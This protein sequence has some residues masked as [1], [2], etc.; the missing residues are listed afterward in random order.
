MASYM[1]VEPLS[2]K[3]FSGGL[4]DNFLQG[5]ARRYAKAD[6]F[7]ITV[8]HKLE[9]RYG[10]VV[11]D[12]V[13]YQLPAPG[14]VTS[15]FTFINESILLAQNN[16]DFFYLPSASSTW[17]AIKGPTGNEALGGGTNYNQVTTAEFQHQ[18]YF[19][20]DAGIQPGKL[21][22]DQNGN[23][24]TLTAGIPRM[25]WVPNYPTDASLLQACITLANALRA[26]FVQHFQDAANLSS[27]NDPRFQHKLV[28]KWSLSYFQSQTW[29]LFDTEYPGP[30]PTPTPAPSATDQT[31]LFNLCLA[32]ALSFEHHR[33]DL[34]GATPSATVPSSGN[35]TY[36][37]DIYY[38]TNQRPS[39]LGINARMLTSGAV[40][41]LTKAAAFLDELAQKWYWH[42][43]SP[44]SHSSTNDYTVMSRYLITASKV[45]TIYQSALTMQVT[46]NYTDYAAFAAWIKKTWN[47]HV[48]NSG[49][50]SSSPHVQVDALNSCTLPDPF[51]YDSASLVLFWTRWAYGNNHLID[52]N[53]GTHTGVTFDTTAAS[54][55]LANV[56]TT[57]TGVALTLP[58]GTNVVTSTA[59]FGDTTVL[60]RRIA[61]VISS[62][63]GTAVLSKPA[64]NT[65]TGTLGQYSS[66]NLHV[67]YLNGSQFKDTTTTTEN[68]ANEALA[69]SIG[70]IGTDLIS[71]IQLAT[72]FLSCYAAHLSNGASHFVGYFMGNDLQGASAING[73]PFYVP[74]AA[75]YTWAAYYN[76]Q[77]T[78]EPNGIIYLTRGNPVISNSVQVLQTYPV[79]TIITSLNSNYY[80]SSTIIQENA[81]ASIVGIPPLVNTSLTNYDTVTSVAPIPSTGNSPDLTIEL[82]RTTNGGTTFFS[83][84]SL[85]NSTASYADVT[86]ELFPRPGDTALN[87]KSVIYTSGGV[88]GNDQPPVCQFIHALNGYVYYGAITDTGQFFPQRIR[89]SN[90][91][92][93]DSAPATNFDDLE[94]ALVG[95]SSNRSNLIALCKNSVYRVSGVFTSTGQGSMAHE[96]I[97]DAIGALNAKS[98]VKTEIGVFFAGTDG[99]YYTDGYQLIKISIEL[100]K[101][102]RSFTTSDTQKARI[103]GCYDKLTRRIWWAMQSSQTGTDNDTFFVFYLNYGVKPDGVFTQAMTKSSWQPSSAIFYKGQL[104]IGDSRGYLLKTDQWT[105]TDPLI[106]TTTTPANWQT[107]YLPYDFRTCALDMG[108]I[109]NRK[110]ITKL[111]AIGENVG[112]AAI[113]V[114]SINDNNA[115]PNGIRGLPPIQY[116]GNPMWGDPSVVWGTASYQWKYDGKMDVWRRFPAGSMRSNFKQVQYS[117]GNFVVYRSADWPLGSTANVSKSGLSAAIATPT[118]YTSIVWPND[119][120]NYVV[121]FDTDGY[122]TTYSITAL[123][124]DK[125]TLTLSDPNGTLANNAAANWQISGIK[126]EQRIKITAF[127]VHFAMLAQGEDSASPAPS[128]AGSVEINP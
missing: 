115:G 109:S 87:L 78:V 19:T 39:G 51:D 12:S 122:V 26:S 105:K 47:I 75:A 61:T 53:F 67:S 32:L 118:G 74:T 124:V 62:G 23:W 52:S 101:T 33:N 30:T 104:V 99:F 58:V 89:Q 20:S 96:R 9:M 121:S 113:Q 102:Y 126:K 91:L 112:N 103:Y 54:T 116:L 82:Y 85:T 70:S 14:R 60:N 5:D 17:N 98:I 81:C 80:N 4:T 31:S 117:P 128:G 45:G 57:A 66:S 22:L 40:T 107:T 16:R 68:Q 21:F 24:K 36:H 71:W 88:L 93:P 42:Q 125:K 110:W 18:L 92:A 49:G 90:Q 11:Y 127:D 94:D 114:N 63:S 37:A 43:L 29:S 7:L 44:L 28:D 83:L 76:Y 48:S 46:P 35:Y 84:T 25:Q 3:D 95:L 2:F 50:A 119:V 97:S 72:E 13:G 106:D 56:K 69:T 10:T 15:L 27:G 65:A 34:A 59:Q 111:H 86:N 108:T 38:A 73:N 79:G 64:L 55:S 77:Y 100:D 123:S 1:D 6:N 8:D 120:V 41:T